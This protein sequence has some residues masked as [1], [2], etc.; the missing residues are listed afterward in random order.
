[1]KQIFRILTCLLVV[2]LL[3]CCLSISIA[4]TVGE[5]NA[6]RT[7]KS[8]LSYTGFSYSGLISQLEF[9]GYTHDEAVYAADHCGA[10]WKANALITAKAY[11][12]YTGFSY[13][14]LINQLEFEG[15]THEEAVYA[16]DICFERTS[17]PPDSTS[18]STPA[19]TLTT[20]TPAISSFSGDFSHYSFNELIAL[21]S[22]LNSALWASDGW[23]KVTVPAGVYVVGED[24][25]AGHWTIAETENSYFRVYK[26][27]YN[28]DLTG[29]LYYSD[30]DGA[31]N[32]KLYDGNYIEIRYHSVV[33]TPYSSGLGF[34]FN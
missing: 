11:L 27:M 28:G 5:K 32:I 19:P 24:I 12:S 18:K 29:L 13:V 34:V 30:L 4:E 26:N 17:T 22:A 3:T 33:F 9:E 2:L 1:M 7:A 16:A 21:Q 23:Q 6:L 31:E 10:D 20:T 14:S 25:P 15:Y 8:Y